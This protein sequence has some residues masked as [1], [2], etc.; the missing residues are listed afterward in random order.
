MKIKNVTVEI[1]PLNEVLGEAAK[2]M[3]KIKKGETVK[4]KKA[5]AKKAVKTPK[6]ARKRK[7]KRNVK[8]KEPIIEEE[9]EDFNI[10]EEDIEIKKRPKEVYELS[11]VEEYLVET[12]SFEDKLK[13]IDPPYLTRYEKARI[14]GARALQISMSAPIFV[15][16]PSYI[17]EPIGIAT[18]ELSLRILPLTIRRHFPN[19]EYV[20]V[21]LKQ[22]ELR[23]DEELFD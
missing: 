9:Y 3:G 11:A 15:E 7:A 1:K 13:V 17:K 4:P 5:K 2:V 23:Y 10:N 8:R 18:F 22:F 21:P 16:I 20:D 14:I 6:V 12:V 19:D